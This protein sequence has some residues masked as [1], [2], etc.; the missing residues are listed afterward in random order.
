[1]PASPSG[2][3]AIAH[4]YHAMAP[5]RRAMSRR[6][7]GGQHV[8]TTR[9]LDPTTT[10]LDAPYSSPDATPTDWRRAHSV[11]AEAAIYWLTTVRADARPHVTPVI[12]VWSDG[13]VH[14][15]TG[16]DE[17]KAKNLSGNPKVI[18]TTGTNVWSGLDVVVEGEAVR[19]TDD[20]TLPRPGRRVGGEVREGMALRRRRRH[21]PPRRRRGARFRHRSQQGLRLRPRRSRRRHALPVLSASGLHERATA[22]HGPAV[23][24]VSGS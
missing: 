15:C 23:V 24:A 22:P 16:P 20:A 2:R 9:D 7:A 21:V 18:V 12:A 14:V 11:L 19:V 5:S 1:M 10:E 13:A 8:M 3:C 4:T 6:V 17:Q